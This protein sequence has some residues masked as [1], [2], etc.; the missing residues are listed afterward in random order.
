MR[1]RKADGGQGPAGGAGVPSSAGRESRFH[2]YATLTNIISE[3]TFGMHTER[4]K[5]LNGLKAQN[6]C[7]HMTDLARGTPA[8]AR[9]RIGL[10]CCRRH[11]PGLC[12]TDRANARVK[13]L[14]STKPHDSAICARPPPP[15]SSVFARS[16]RRLTSHLYGEVPTDLAKV[17]E[18]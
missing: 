3:R 16:I 10:P 12:P 14:W 17:R 13:W 11:R 7:D 6:L 18:K 1:A 9:S 4:H 2:P 5:R 8:T 15:N